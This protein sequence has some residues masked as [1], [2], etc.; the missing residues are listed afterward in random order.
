MVQD[1]RFRPRQQALQ[2]CNPA[3]KTFLRMAALSS[4]VCGLRTQDLG[5]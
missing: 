5:K 3:I 1:I 4:Y 2:A